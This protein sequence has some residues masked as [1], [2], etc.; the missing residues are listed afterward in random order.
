MDISQEI[1]IIDLL[2]LREEQFRKVWLLEESVR[3]LLN[4]AG[5]SFPPPPSLPSRQKV[6]RQTRRRQVSQPV[7]S[8]SLIPSLRPL[9]GARENA[10]RVVYLFK[11]EE[12]ESFQR[13]NDFLQTLSQL[14]SESFR[15][16]RIETV[17]SHSAVDY[18]VIAE[19]FR[20]NNA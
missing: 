10:Y 14:T 17:E 6:P 18:Q 9:Q 5:V 15:L 20:D 19:L 11:G 7:Q 2:Y 12:K 1:K 16:L 8:A 13:D 4:G 3:N